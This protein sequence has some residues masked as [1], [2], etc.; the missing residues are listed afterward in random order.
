M[1]KVNPRVDL[2]I[3]LNN[4]TLKKEEKVKDC[5]ALRKEAEKHLESRRREKG[6]GKELKL[7]RCDF[8]ALQFPKS[9]RRRANDL[10]PVR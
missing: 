4:T 5:V 2:E 3:I 7:A 9:Q 6:C 10:Q 8:A 1:F